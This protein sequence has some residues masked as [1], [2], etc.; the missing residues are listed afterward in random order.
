MF[1]FCFF[2]YTAENNAFSQRGNDRVM[3]DNNSNEYG[4]PCSFCEQHFDQCV[5]DTETFSPND[6]YNL[7]SPL[8]GQHSRHLCSSRG[9]PQHSPSDQ[10]VYSISSR[11][12]SPF[13]EGDVSMSF[14]HRQWCSNSNIASIDVVREGVAMETTGTPPL[15]ALKSFCSSISPVIFPAAVSASRDAL[16]KEYPCCARNSDQFVLD[17]VFQKPNSCRLIPQTAPPSSCDLSPPLA[18]ESHDL[19]RPWIA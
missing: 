11:E 13:E 5:E 12:E 17:P 16:S 14:S 15:R 18:P 10:S 7:Q 19:W 1:F 4:S 8:D 3:D 6:S 2:L 9:V